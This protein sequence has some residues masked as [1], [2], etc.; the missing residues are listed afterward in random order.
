[1]KFRKG[2]KVLINPDIGNVKCRGVIT[3]FQEYPFSDMVLYNVKLSVE[4]GPTIT[5]IPE[6]NI[7]SL[8]GE[9]E[10]T[11]P[12][13]KKFGTDGLIATLEEITEQL[14]SND[15]KLVEN[16]VNHDNDTQKNKHYITI[17]I[18]MEDI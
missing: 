14:K 7:I 1:M 5:D 4:N 15:V 3:D 18:V 8:E 13:K 6:A 9:T 2:E 11:A 12:S 16:V 17:N 10:E